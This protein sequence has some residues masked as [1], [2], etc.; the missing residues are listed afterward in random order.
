MFFLLT[1]LFM[2]ESLVEIAMISTVPVPGIPQA[3]SR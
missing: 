3:G 1:G 2:T